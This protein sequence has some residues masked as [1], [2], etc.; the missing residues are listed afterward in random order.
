MKPA[1][2]RVA[3][4]AAA[5]ASLGACG[6]R[7]DDGASLSSSSVAGSAATP[8]PTSCPDGPVTFV[9]YGAPGWWFTESFE[10]SAP[11]ESWLSVSCECGAE[12]LLDP[13]V[14]TT[15]RDCGSCPQVWES[16]GVDSASP[17][18]AE[19]IHR[20]W[21][22]MRYLE[23]TCGPSLQCVR[24]TC[25]APGQYVAKM[26]GCAPKD[27]VS[28]ACNKPVCVSVPFQYPGDASVEGFLPGTP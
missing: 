6:G 12:L 9:L 13:T 22:G 24:P 28:G 1:F 26:C 23:A 17:L 10:N 18:P 19:G 25:A 14:T 27:V 4:V 5:L 7:V 21:N 20:V 3:V 8:E 2:T 16:A 15:T 11:G